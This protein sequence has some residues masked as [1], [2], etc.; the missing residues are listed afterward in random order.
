MES[1]LKYFDIKYNIKEFINL[2]KETKNI[3]ETSFSVSKSQMLNVFFTTLLEY[4][5][6]N[7]TLN[8]DYNDTSISDEIKDNLIKKV[9]PIIYKAKAAKMFNLVDFMFKTFRKVLVKANSGYLKW[10]Q[11]PGVFNIDF[12]VSLMPN[13]DILFY[14]IFVNV[15]PEDLK[16]LLRKELK[17]TSLENNI[18]TKCSGILFKK[19]K[20]C[21]FKNDD[22]S[23]KNKKYVN[24]NSQYGI[25]TLF[26]L[27]NNLRPFSTRRYSKIDV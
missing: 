2:E 21:N 1:L 14:I 22:L 20:I 18:L 27:F 9:Y 12:T 7:D 16:I 4:Y 23:K 25:I 15:L 8:I 5:Y 13:I 24:I 17:I 11:K 3:T 6:K 19:N 26:T 10:M